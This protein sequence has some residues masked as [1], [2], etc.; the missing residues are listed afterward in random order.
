MKN[1][2]VVEDTNVEDVDAERYQQHKY[3][4]RTRMKYG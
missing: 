4:C 2:I 3:K 1:K